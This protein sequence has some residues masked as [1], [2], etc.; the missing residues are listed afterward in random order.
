MVGI[1]ALIQ[2]IQRRKSGGT[3]ESKFCR[4]GDTL[5]VLFQPQF[6]PEFG[7]QRLYT[8]ILQGTS[9]FLDLFG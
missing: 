1:F 6:G 2:K 4:I 3:Q 5:G 9:W 7:V 8:G